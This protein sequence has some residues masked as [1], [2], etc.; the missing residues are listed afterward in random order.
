RPDTLFGATFM[1]IAPEHELLTQVKD[2]ITNWPQVEEYLIESQ[3]KS[4]LER[5][6]EK[7]KTGLK[8]E[9]IQAINPVNGKGIPVFAADYV[10]MG[11]GTGAIMAVPAHDQRDWDFARKYRLPVVE[12]IRGE[13]A[14]LDKQAFEGEGVLVNSGEFNGTP[15]AEGIARV[16]AWL[17]T[18]GLG[19]K[20]VNY[21]L[22]EWLISRQRYWGTPIPMIHCEKCG[23]VP[24]PEKDLPVLL[25]QDVKLTGTGESPLASNPE[26]INIA[27]PKCGGPARRETDTMDTFVDSSWYYSRYC[28][29]KNDRAPF[30][31][32][33][34]NS[35]LPVDQYIGGIE[36]ACMHLIYSRFWFKVMRDLGLVRNEEPF[37]NLLT[38]GMVTLGGSAMSKSRGNIVTP[39][40][41]ITKYGADTARLFI[42]FAAPP[43]KQLDWSDD[44]LEGSWRFLNRVWRL[45]DKFESPGPAADAGE[46]AR[47]RLLHRIHTTIQKVTSDIEKEKQLNTAI[48]AVMELVNELYGYPAPGDGVWRQGVATSVKL[49]APFTPHIT[50]ELWERLGHAESLLDA[51]WPVADERYLRAETL[52]LP[53]Q[54]N[55]KLRGKITVS[56]EIA[57]D[58]LRRAV[59]ED[60]KLAP[61]LENRNIVKF[62]YVKG[63]IVNVIVK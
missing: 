1:V 61:Y 9:G 11:Y 55:G 52:D 63:R 53:V 19:K 14:D 39:D 51:P 4:N 24:V 33:T 6:S 16:S 49:L 58:E 13:G 37:N 5:S 30:S 29:P 40:E 3:Q 20:A 43:A 23:T 12:V 34:A 38:Q 54:I 17:E 47:A 42:L 60:V 7:A 27:C 48:S 15:S 36:H 50:E 26:F 57:E 59:E 10:L 28:D 2:K 41:I 44:G 45:L 22:K 62:I 8:V 35:W 46:A 21:R 56:P 25:P 32:D 18:K 31:P